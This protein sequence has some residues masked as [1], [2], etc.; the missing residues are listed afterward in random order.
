M[1]V[2]IIIAHPLKNSLSNYF[3]QK[4]ISKLKEQG[5]EIIIEDLYVSGF[6][7]ALDVNERETYYQNYD[8][9]L[10]EK[11]TKQLQQADALILIFPTWW[12]GFPA[13]LKG[14]FDRVWGPSIAFEHANNFGPITPKLNNLRRVMTITTLGSP[15]WVDRLIMRQPVK[16]IL[17]LALL[18]TCA[19]QCKFEFYSLYESEKPSE[20]DLEKFSNRF[21]KELNR[22]R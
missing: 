14:W 7:P 4:A 21:L 3:A 17:K 12:F 10:I 1:K 5:H 20:K 15:W 22:W 16:R 19:P 11:Q 13:I 9:S 18:K 2:L 8:I 6:N